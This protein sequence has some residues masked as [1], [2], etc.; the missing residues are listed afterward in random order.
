MV[1]QS[2]VH[3]HQTKA[4]GKI[5]NELTDI[6]P[7]FCRHY[8]RTDGQSNKNT[9]I[10]IGSANKNPS[11]RRRRKCLRQTGKNNSNKI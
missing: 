11:L 7:K 8:V 6:V 2:L 9:A 1:Q 3:R 10:T 4:A 5:R